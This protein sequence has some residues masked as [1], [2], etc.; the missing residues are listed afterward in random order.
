MRVLVRDTHTGKEYWDTES[1]VNIFVPKGQYPDFKV[2]VNPKSMLHAGIDTEIGIDM[3][4]GKDFTAVN[5]KVIDTYTQT[6][7]VIL[8]DMTKK[9]LHEYALQNNVEI[10]LTAKNKKDIISHIDDQLFSE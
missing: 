3:A 5:G 9:Q 10:P 6:D 8:E 2:T 7:D 1:K 4:D